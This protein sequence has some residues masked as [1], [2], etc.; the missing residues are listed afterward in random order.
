MAK[1]ILGVGVTN[2]GLGGYIPQVNRTGFVEIRERKLFFSQREMG[3]FIPKTLRGGYGDLPAGI[4]L[5]EDVNS[6]FLVPYIPDVTDFTKDLGRIALVTDNVTA[7]TFQ[8]WKE[9]SG[10]IKTGDV[11]VLTDSDGAWEEATVSTVL[12]LDDR[13][14]TVTLSAATVTVGGFT[15]AKSASCWLKAGT[16]NKRSTAKYLL[17]QDTYTGEYD[18]PNGSLSSVFLSNG[19]IYKDSCIGLDAT[20]VTALGGTID[21]SFLI[22]K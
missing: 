9:D 12:P 8:I 21:G 17:D 16:A 2:A 14:Y 4:I 10:K 15:I 7:T 1:P 5:A 18:N 20:A 22:I 19:V 11:I 3:L 6:G 13:R